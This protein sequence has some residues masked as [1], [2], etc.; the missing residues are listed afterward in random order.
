[1]TESGNR[2]SGIRLVIASEAKQ[3]RD[4]NSLN[5][6]WIVLSSVIANPASVGEAIYLL[7]RCVRVDCFVATLLATTEER[8]VFHSEGSARSPA[9]H[10]A[11]CFTFDQ[12]S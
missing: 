10:A 8:P 3:S 1:V 5:Q 11:G 7:A 2:Q 12:S 6:K 9:S 4:L